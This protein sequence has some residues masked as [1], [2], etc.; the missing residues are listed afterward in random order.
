[1][2]SPRKNVQIGRCDSRLERLGPVYTETQRGP[3]PSSPTLER[4]RP[5]SLF[6][7]ASSLLQFVPDRSSS[8]HT[9]VCTHSHVWTHVAST[10]TRAHID[11]C[12]TGTRTQGCDPP[13]GGRTRAHTCVSHERT[14]QVPMDTRRSGRTPGGRSPD[15]EAPRSRDSGVPTLLDRRGRDS[16]DTRGPVWSGGVRAPE[17]SRVDGSGTVLYVGSGTG[18]GRERGVVSNVETLVGERVGHGGA[19]GS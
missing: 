14:T 7:G 19:G 2:G 5:F 12:C 15:H 11:S 16:V 3:R 1:M 8:S 6:T 17:G 9:R 10:Y 18:V 13:V 4:S